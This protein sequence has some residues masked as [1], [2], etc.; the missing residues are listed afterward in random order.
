MPK[1]LVVPKNSRTSGKFSSWTITGAGAGDKQALENV[2]PFAQ[3]LM[4]ISEPSQEIQNRPVGCEILPQ[5]DLSVEDIADENDL[6]CTHHVP[7]AAQAAGSAYNRGLQ[8]SSSPDSLQ[9][10]PKLGATHP[11]E[12]GSSISGSRRST[13]D[14]FGKLDHFSLQPAIPE[15]SPRQSLKQA[16]NKDFPG[17]LQPGKETRLKVRH[18]RLPIFPL[19]SPTVSVDDGCRTEYSGFGEVCSTRGC[20]VLEPIVVPKPPTCLWF[21]SG[22]LH[23]WKSGT[24]STRKLILSTSDTMCGGRRRLVWKNSVRGLSCTSPS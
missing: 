19:P 9:D 7:D 18:H 2:M 23:P 22:S 1:F 3:T 12:H 13:Y 21:C 24:N 10:R 16:G 15:G 8:V 20:S 11:G 14:G 4:E 5:S 6:E 17:A